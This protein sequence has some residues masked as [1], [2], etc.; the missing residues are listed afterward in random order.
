MGSQGVLGFGRGITIIT[1][2][3]QI[4]NKFFKGLE[5]RMNR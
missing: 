1:K 5:K 2:L 3:E 4:S